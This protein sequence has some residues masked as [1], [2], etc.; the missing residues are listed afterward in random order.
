M[1]NPFNYRFGLP[2]PFYDNETGSFTPF[3]PASLFA[4]NEPGVWYDPSDIST[5]YQDTAGTTPVTA[6][7]QTV[8]LM[9][10]KSKGL[11]LGSE[12]VISV[13]GWT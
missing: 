5:L 9:L 8:A 11:T 7:A 10:D 4:S 13:V 3:S 2:S 12:L 1:R 6:P